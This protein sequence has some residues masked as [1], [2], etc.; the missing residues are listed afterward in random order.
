MESATGNKRNKETRIV[1]KRGRLIQEWK[2]ED[3]GGGR[4]KEGE[5]GD[6]LICRV[7]NNKAERKLA[8]KYYSCVTSYVSTGKTGEGRAETNAPKKTSVMKMQMQ[9]KTIPTK[10]TPGSGIERYG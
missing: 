8:T 1:K 6:L 3:A 2:V 4:R 7:H 5:G 9:K 10:I